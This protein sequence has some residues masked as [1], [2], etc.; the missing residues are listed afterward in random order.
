MPLRIKQIFEP[1]RFSGM[2]QPGRKTTGPTEPYKLVLLRKEK[3]LTADL[4]N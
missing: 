1:A 4:I 3:R 2:Q